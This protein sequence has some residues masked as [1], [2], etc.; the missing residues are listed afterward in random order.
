M[1]NTSRNGDYSYGR[2]LEDNA[3]LNAGSPSPAIDGGRLE[4][5]MFLNSGLTSGQNHM[6]PSCSTVG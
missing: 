2:S 6:I 5:A 1:C 4:E 3:S